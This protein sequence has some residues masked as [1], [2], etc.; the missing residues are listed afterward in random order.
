M[1]DAQTRVIVP[2]AEVAAEAYRAVFGQ[3]GL[4]LDL[5]WLPLLVMLA[6]A[7][8][9]GYLDFYLG[10]NAIPRWDSD[11][12]GFNVEDLIQALAGLLCLNAFAVRWHQAM[13]FA[14]VRSAPSGTFLGAWIR[15]LLY[16]LLFYLI[17]AGLFAALLIG[18][19]ESAPAYL[20]PVAGLLA[21]ILCVG[22]VRCSLLFPA[23]AFGKPLGMAR[24]WQAMRGNAWRLLGCGFIACTPMLMVLVLILSGI[25]TALHLD[26][27]PGRLP[28]GFF[29]LRAVIETCTNLV[30]VA[31]GAT[32]L[33]TFYRRIML[34]AC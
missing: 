17:L 2:V 14:G 29:I 23:A 5:A 27:L 22:T 34:R 24:A 7:L 6:A 25:F 28:L 11:A 8:L 31:L 15:F 1:A 20:A 32:V 18:S 21:T 4:L 9:P 26:Q 13:L 10:W 19:A 33:S 16:A 30:I 12:F 3:F